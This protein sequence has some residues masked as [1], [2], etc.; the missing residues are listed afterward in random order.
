MIVRNAGY[1]V[2]LLVYPSVFFRQDVYFAY[3]TISTC[4]ERCSTIRLFATKHAR[5]ESGHAI[6]MVLEV[7][8]V[9][10]ETIFTLILHDA[11]SLDDGSS[12]DVPESH[13]AIAAARV[14]DC[15]IIADPDRLDHACVTATLQNALDV[16]RP[17]INHM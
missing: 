12:A 15:F 5:H 6:R 3:A 13:R 16:L 10:T 14:A 8:N 2:I 1:R 17:H 4:G 7:I 11:I 9:C